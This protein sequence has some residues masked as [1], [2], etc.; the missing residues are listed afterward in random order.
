M[1]RLIILLF[2]SNTLFAQ[3]AKTIKLYD[4][5]E[6]KKLNAVNRELEALRESDNRFV[7]L[8]EKSGTEGIVWIPVDDFTNGVIELELRGKDVFQKS[9]IGVAFH[10]QDNNI[11]DAIYCRPFNFLAKDSV[12]KLH[13]IQYIAH[14]VYTWKKLREEKNGVY[15]KEIVV[16]PD[17]NGWFR[18]KIVIADRLVNAYINDATKPSLTVEKL[19]DSRS[20]KIGLFVGAGSGGDFKNIKI[21]YA[22]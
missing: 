3:H 17:P 11:Y 19:T 4:L 22:R 7:R 20:G 13:A 2:L 12:R 21:E 5:H 14:P 9:F 18:M 1:Y 6:E 10:G 8:S 15:E 16:P